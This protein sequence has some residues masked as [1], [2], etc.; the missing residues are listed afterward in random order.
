MRDSN[1]F[2]HIITGLQVGG[3]ERALY[4]LI[5]GGLADGESMSILS[6]RD[7]GA[8][9]ASIRELGVPV[10]SLGVIGPVPGAISMWH[11]RKL[12]QEMQP[13][14][15]QG[16][17]YH[18]N[19]AACAASRLASSRPIVT[20]NIRQCL[21]SLMNEKYITRQ[22]IR[23]NG[24]LSNIPNAII[25]NSNLSKAHHE[26]F[27]FAHDKGRVIP[28]GFDI[29]TLTPDINVRHAVRLH[30]A[31][32]PETLLVGHVGRY[33]PMK[34]HVSFL[35]AAVQVAMRVPEAIFLLIGRGVNLENPY[36][37]QIV[38]GALS[39]RFIF[40][41]ERSDVP[42]LMQAMDVF[43][44]SSWSEAFPNVL[45]EAMSSGVPCVAT[46]V[47][48]SAR[49]VGD[50]GLLVPASDSYALAEAL[51]SVLTMPIERRLAL[52]RKARTR[53]KENYD[54]SRV[55]H[56]YKALYEELV[57]GTR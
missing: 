50:A 11:L 24:W 39:N 23:S 16:W 14:V 37:R 7:E 17:M 27:G 12:V 1:K 6:L 9:G 38:P 48:D 22:I 55:V 30:L 18:G 21:Y 25:Y 2:L 10:Y 19:L 13:D 56:M 41:G 52:G 15:I 43:C 42:K 36:L 28:N 44:Q 45:G 29:D 20:W 33:H 53:I 47:G 57:D 32:S 35:R 5:L 34:D 3:A 54:L 51:I 31:I 26:T 46:N 8:L 49:I 4:N 40:L